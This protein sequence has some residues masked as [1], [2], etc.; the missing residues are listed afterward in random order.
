MRTKDNGKY[1][2]AGNTG[3]KKCAAFNWLKGVTAVLCAVAMYF[4]VTTGIRGY[5]MYKD[6]IAQVSLKDKVSE[7]RS[8][9]SYTVFSDL[10]E[11]YTDAVLSVEDHRFYGHIGID[12][13]AITRAM[14]N[15]VKAGCFVEGGSTITQQLAKNQ[16]FTQDKKIVRKVAEMF[17]AFKIESELDKDTIFELYVNS[18]FFGNGYYC[19]ADASNGYFGKVPSE[20][21]FDECTLLAGV[22]NA[23]TNYNP[24]ASPELARQRQKQVIEKMKKA[25]YLEESV[26]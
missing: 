15:D 16:Y 26:D 19:V 2:I 20:M 7:I 18:I 11:T 10:P 22:P 6:A 9:E 4:A 23:P 5:D 24:T 1:N 12:P 3:K 21:N 17:M 25:G 14:V 8:K 13:I